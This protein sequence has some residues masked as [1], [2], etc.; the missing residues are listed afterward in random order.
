M[1]LGVAVIVWVWAVALYLVAYYLATWK[2]S[3][4]ELHAL[5]GQEVY[6]AVIPLGGWRVTVVPSVVFALVVALVGVSRGWLAGRAAAFSRA[7][8]MSRRA[9]SFA[10]QAALI[11]V[12][13]PVVHAGVDFVH[14][15]ILGVIE[16]TERAERLEQ[17]H[18]AAAQAAATDPIATG[19]GMGALVTT[20]ACAWGFGGER[21]AFDFEGRYRREST[22]CV[23][24]SMTEGRYEQHD[25][26]LRLHRPIGELPEDPYPQEYPI[27]L[28][29]V[30]WGGRRYLLRE[31][32]LLG[33]CHA[34]NDGTETS[35][36]PSGRFLLRSEDAE[37]RATGMPVLSAPWGELL[38]PAPLTGRVIESTAD[39]GAWVDL[40]SEDGLRAGLRL[41]VEGVPI[42]PASRHLFGQREAM[43]RTFEV[44]EVEA[45]R[46]R[47]ADDQQQQAETMMSPV[48]VGSVV[49]SL[50]PVGR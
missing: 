18:E 44:V 24:G 30:R 35:A 10:S 38:L 28:H 25:G 21:I 2:W 20:Y 23:A 41:F 6:N 22:G 46:S 7:T 45:H 27:E 12:S 34:V 9:A 33:F 26:V 14:G 13:V 1:W 39:H 49:T 42:L 48:P 37:L 15:S 3:A 17:L 8:R 16:R 4:L 32:E 5:L 40:G 50:R 47:L 29:D 43:W 19:E 36:K 31:S 11:V